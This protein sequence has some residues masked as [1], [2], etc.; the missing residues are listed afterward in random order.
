MRLFNY[1]GQKGQGLAEYALIFSMVIAALLAMQTYIKRGL[2]GKY[3]DTADEITFAL[4][5]I[6]GDLNLPLQYE[7]H[8]TDSRITTTANQ[9][10]TEKETLGGSKKT[11]INGTVKRQGYQ[12]ILPAGE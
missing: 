12:K 2:Q 9:S 11:T 1:N 7:P 4:R 8:Y 5:E 3:K 10:R 6:K